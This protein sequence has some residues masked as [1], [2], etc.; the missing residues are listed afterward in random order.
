M[1][2]GQVKAVNMDYQFQ[3]QSLNNP[4]C[5]NTLTI[6]IKL[7]HT[8]DLH[9]HPVALSSWQIPDIQFWPR[10]FQC[11]QSSA[12]CWSG[13]PA[14]SPH[15]RWYNNHWR[16]ED[17]SPRSGKQGK[18]V[19]KMLAAKQTLLSIWMDCGFVLL[20][21]LKC[22]WSPRLDESLL[23]VLSSLGWRWLL[24]LQEESKVRHR[25]QYGMTDMSSNNSVKK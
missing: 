9:L 5:N 25:K 15:H 7:W 24:S 16:Y 13:L 8:T 1:F 2:A 3:I 17:C 4:F 10:A 22:V 20:L 12:V 23:M 6:I 19:M 18:K 14:G 21:K 11:L